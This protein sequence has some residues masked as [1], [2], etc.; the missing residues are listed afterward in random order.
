[1]ASEEDLKLQIETLIKQINELGCGI[2]YPKT[3]EIMLEEENKQI[4]KYLTDLT[5]REGVL[6]TIASIFTLFPVF[7]TNHSM[8]DGFL[9]W[10]APFLF[11]GIVTYLL[12]S[13]RIHV[14]PSLAVGGRLVT[15]EETN[16]VL[17]KAY[18]KVL[19]WHDM[20]DI[21]FVAFITSFVLNYYIYVFSEPTNTKALIVLGCSLI[22]AVLRY[23]FVTRTG[24]KQDPSQ[25]ATGSGPSED[26]QIGVG[27]T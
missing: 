26:W 20:T 16:V 19:K 1:M 10:T 24:D 4:E 13:K 22:L 9:L 2:D 7:D 18:F 23:F 11:I 6:I 14:I 8:S 3:K 5:Q 12:S 25:I 15:A 21:S 27:G 17:K